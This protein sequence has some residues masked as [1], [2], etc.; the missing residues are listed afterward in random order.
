M[1]RVDSLRNM[2]L[3]RAWKTQGGQWLDTLVEEACLAYPRS[4][5]YLASTARP[6]FAVIHAGIA[7]L[8]D[9]PLCKST[10]G[11]DGAASKKH[12]VKLDSPLD[13][14][15]FGSTFCQECLARLPVSRMSEVMTVFGLG[16][17]THTSRAAAG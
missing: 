11:S 9:H 1:R 15:D 10:K 4:D 5:H 2:Q 17:S 12:T 13:A 16:I 3:D 7:G 6:S 8:P 14:L